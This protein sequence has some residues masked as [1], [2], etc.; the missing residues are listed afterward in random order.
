MKKA[1]LIVYLFYVGSFLNNPMSNSIVNLTIAM[2]DDHTFE[3]TPYSNNSVDVSIKDGKY[4]S[5]M[6][7]GL[8]LLAI[9]VYI[10]AK[11]ITLP[12]PEAT[13]K[14]IEAKLQSSLDHHDGGDERN[15]KRFLVLLT[16][17]LIILL[18]NLPLAFL[19]YSFLENEVKSLS[20]GN[21]ALLIFFLM[22][23]LASYIPQNFHNAICVLLLFSCFLLLRTQTHFPGR[24]LLLGFGLGL[25]PTMDY[26]AFSYA[27]V[28]MALVVLE[29]IK[30]LKNLFAGYELHYYLSVQAA[31]LCYK[32]K[33]ISVTWAYPSKGT[34]VTK[35]S[36][37]RG[38]LKVLSC[39]FKACLGHYD[40]EYSPA[41]MI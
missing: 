29:N 33:E 28:I 6:P 23:P 27:L 36:P 20:Y 11:L 38:N 39:L 14:V 3:I 5:G 12:L 21:L 41:N 18:I 13:L 40:P 10:F 35:I 34:V 16:C 25:I 31:K 30:H 22:T 8:S 37:I 9:P 24:F 1:L 7:P 2:V 4:F 17:F 26:P 32:I 15:Q 19:C